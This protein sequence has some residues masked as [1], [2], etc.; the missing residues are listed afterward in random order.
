M[1]AYLI[2][3]RIVHILFG[4]FWAGAILFMAIFIE[5]SV[6]EAGPAGGQ[7]MQGLQR[8]KFMTVMPWIAF[9]TLLSGLLLMD[10]MAGGDHAGYFGSPVGM[11]I[12][13]GFVLSTVAFLLGIFVMRPAAMKAG[14]LAAKLQAGTADGDPESVKAEI[15]AFQARSRIALRTI[16]VLL[17]L[18]VITMAVGRYM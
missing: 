13:M 4:V 9:F 3:L 15:V 12:G 7:V 16:A 17:A 14:A 11:A 1:E 10:R 8:R 6:R 18:T 2:L 5:P